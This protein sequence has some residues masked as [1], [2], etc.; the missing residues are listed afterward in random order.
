MIK[1]VFQYGQGD[2]AT[3]AGGLTEDDTY[4]TSILISLLSQRRVDPDET[5]EKS[6]LGGWFGDSFPDIEGDQIGSKL[7]LLDGMKTTDDT[8][9]KAEE[10]AAE[11]LEWM[12]DDGIT[13]EITVVARRVDQDVLDIEVFINRPDDT[14]DVWL[15]TWEASIASLG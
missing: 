14:A 12:K 6:N 11:A 10:W 5:Q 13:D 15:G 9:T 8:L 7:W 1:L 3:D 4:Q 2:L